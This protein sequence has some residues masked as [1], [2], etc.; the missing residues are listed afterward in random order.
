MTQQLD[1]KQLIICV[2]L[3][4]SMVSATP[5]FG[6]E[7]TADTNITQWV[8]DALRHDERVGASEIQV[9]TKAGLVT[10][11]GSVDNLAARQF[12]AQEA[13]KINGVHGVIN[14]IVVTPTWRSDADLCHMV[15]RRLLNSAVIESQALQIACE[16]GRVTL[17]GQVK[18][19]TEWE[20]ASLLASQVRGVKAVKN[21]L[22]I[23]WTGVRSDQ[24]IGADAIA[25]L[26]RDVYLSGLPITVTVQNGVVTLIGS[27]EN[28][29]EKERVETDIRSVSHVATIQNDLQVKPGDNQGVGTQQSP[30][31]DEALKA[32]VQTALH[33][34]SRV[35]AADNFLTVSGGHV[36]L[37]GFVANQAEKRIAEQ[38]ARAVGGVGWVTNGL[39]ARVDGRE[40]WA[41]QDDVNF[42]F[43]T[44]YL[45]ESSDLKPQVKNGV[46][47]LSGV[48]HTEHEKAHAQ[49]VASRVKG[50]KQVVNQISVSRVH[51]HS[52]TAVLKA[53]KQR[54]KWNWI[55]HRVSDEIEV[56]VKDGVATLSGEVQTWAQRNE[57]EQVAFKTAGVWAVDNKLSVQG[58]DY[59][60]EE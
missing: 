21:T 18:S 22:A 12:A 52:E 16:D 15:R 19:W 47:T 5:T 33:Q 30:P 13:G 6:A 10:L 49:E 39:F 40:D 45:L 50:V 32:A 44:D 38:D 46:L 35:N 23:Q 34:D 37:D 20:E 11:S 3:I 27:V 7:P 2:V 54:L 1:L 31:S 25:A 42:T 56:T 36:T 29:Y 17:T 8:Q 14:E 53:I 57:A 28:A 4:C 58:Y 59:P 48:V 60:W 9:S 26:E 51:Q 41:I 24:A 43:D 55:T